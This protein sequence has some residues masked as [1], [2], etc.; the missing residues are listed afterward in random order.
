MADFIQKSTGARFSEAARNTRV[1]NGANPNDFAE[2]GSAAASA[3]TGGPAVRVLNDTEDAIFVN[4]GA[5]ITAGARLNRI[6]AGAN[7]PGDFAP[8]SETVPATVALPPVVAVPAVVAP[9]APAGP[10]PAS[11]TVRTSGIVLSP[12]AAANYVARGLCAPEDLIPEGAAPA[13]VVADDVDV[14]GVLPLDV[15]AFT[16]AQLGA[17]AS[18]LGLDDTG[19]K[20]TLAAR[21][22]DHGDEAGTAVAIAALG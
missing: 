16:R 12:E 8:L 17:I 22:N 13:A 21:I 18:A 20:A 15:E 19:S 10:A 7:V 14:D 3:V 4:N 2:V 1:D 6:A 11:Y 5:R 9:A